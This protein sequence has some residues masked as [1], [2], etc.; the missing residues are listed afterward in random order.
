MK[1]DRIIGIDFSLNSPGFCILDRDQ[2]KWISL[3]RTKNIIDKMLKKDGSPFK[4]L[5]DN[6]NVDINI[7]EKKEFKGEYH[8]IERDKIIN[9]VYFSEVVMNLLEPYI[10]ENTIVGMEGLSF[11]SSG[12]SLIDISM[13]TALVRSAIVKIIKP[14][15]FFVIS[16]T[17]IKKFA[18]KGNSKKDELYN[19]ILEKRID[20][21]RLKPFL[22]ILKEYKDS[23]IKGSN[24][25][26]GPCSDLVDATWISLFVEENLEKLLCGKKI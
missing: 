5:N 16:P 19:A 9:A 4:I 13:T 26:E 20:D 2:C 22:D 10:D 21:L 7:I 24:K 8:I 6:L 15:N 14:N 11:G 3:H 17:S 12:N 18:L 23:W 25:V 1:S